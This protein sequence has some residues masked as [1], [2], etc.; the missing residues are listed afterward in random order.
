M[1]QIT[2]LLM[3]SLGLPVWSQNLYSQPPGVPEAGP[4]PLWRFFSSCGSYGM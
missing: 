2:Q 1:P 3:W 4:S